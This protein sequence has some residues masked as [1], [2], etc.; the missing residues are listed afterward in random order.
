MYF[1][2]TTPLPAA[3]ATRLATRASLAAALALSATVASA[4]SLETNLGRADSLALDQ[5]R[6]VF[7]I[8]D[9]STSP[10]TLI[11]P[12]LNTALLDTGANGILLAALSY[13]DGED[14]GQPAFAFDYDGNGTI[15]FDEQLAQYAELG[16]AGTTLLDVH[17][18]N[19]LRIE[20][21]DGVERLIGTD[22]RPFGDR[23]LNIGSFAAIVGMP[24]MQGL[25]VEIDMRPNANFDFQRVAFH[26]NINQAAFES[27]G[28]LNV[29][30]RIIEPEFTDPTFIDN[31]RPDLLPTF[32]GL[33]VID[34][35][36]MTN[37]GGA[38]S[39]GAT[40]TADDY[41]FLVDTGA[42]TTIISEQ[43]AIDMGIDFLN[44]AGVGGD[45]VDALEVGGIGGTVLMPLVSVDRFVMPSQSGVDIVLTDMLVGVLDI[46][47]APFDAVL[48]MNVLTTGYLG[49]AF[50]GGDASTGLV[51]D[52][53]PDE[54]AFNVLV[55]FGFVTTIDDLFVDLPLQGPVLNITREEYDLLVESQILPD[56]DDPLVAY[57][58]ALELDDEFTIDPGELTGPVFDK[59]VFDF[60]AE[61]TGV[62]RLDLN[63]PLVVV[64]EPSSMV[65]LGLAGAMIAMRRRRG[66]PTS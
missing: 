52:D 39:G 24:A 18:R 11:G 3:A 60:T 48:G 16:V 7:G 38:N 13:R 5:P 29:D 45:V 63:Q 12:T 46:D 42:Q 9:E 21:S 4:G 59:V 56:T 58:A 1:N 44:G 53:V 65:L 61:E 6:V 55:E 19:G 23:N 8:T 62:M 51:D 2:M 28:Q 47:G 22:I 27:Q 30:L 37:T 50:G 64:P 14:Y 20:D 49:A 17:D 34:N 57:R 36:D 54:D 40:L 26:D 43:M 33:P 41:T 15:D 35:V 66:V 32:A 31:G 25:A 10:A